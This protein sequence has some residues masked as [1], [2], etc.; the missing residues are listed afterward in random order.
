ML[1]Y[2]SIQ[3]QE[4]L[5]CWDHKIKAVRTCQKLIYHNLTLGSSWCRDYHRETS[6]ALTVTAG[7]E[8]GML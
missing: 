7:S 5:L 8:V 3:Q 1:V 2:I 6:L 4:A